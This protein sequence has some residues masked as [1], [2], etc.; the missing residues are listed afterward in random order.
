[1]HVCMI[2]AKGTEKTWWGEVHNVWVKGK[3]AI[4]SNNI[5]KKVSSECSIAYQLKQDLLKISHH[6]TS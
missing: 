4:W 3:H 2:Y 5:H 6:T 1:M